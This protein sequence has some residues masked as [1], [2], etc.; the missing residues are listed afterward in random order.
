[1]KNANPTP[2]MRNQTKDMLYTAL[3]WVAVFGSSAL[4]T[5]CVQFLRA[6]FR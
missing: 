4:A 5:Y 6:T 2:L 3:F 1:M